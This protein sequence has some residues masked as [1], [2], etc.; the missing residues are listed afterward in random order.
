MLDKSA[1]LDGPIPGA[2]FTSDTKN[3]PWH[4]PPKYTDLDDAIEFSFNHLMDEEKFASFLT[5]MKSGVTILQAA[6]MFTMAGVGAGKWTVDFALLMAGPV[7]HIMWLM[8]K[9]YGI[10]PKLGIEKK[11]K[12]VMSATVKALKKTEDI[13]RNKIKA[14]TKMIDEVKIEQAAER[15]TPETPEATGFMSGGKV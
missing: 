9:A 7:A 14:A 13:D 11:R 8:C 12:P 5:M 2:N 15:L 10:T 4:R 1:L 3:Y 6:D